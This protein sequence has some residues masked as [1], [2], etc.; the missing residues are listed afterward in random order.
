MIE[1]FVPLDLDS[2]VLTPEHR[3]IAASARETMQKLAA[4]GFAWTSYVHGQV[5]AVMCAA[6]MPDGCEVFIFP[7]ATL[8]KRNPF[9]LFKDVATKL[10]DAKA[11]F[12]A[13]RSVT[14]P[15]AP[16]ANRF[17]AHL[18]FKRE[19]MRGEFLVWVLAP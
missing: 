18:G 19:G 13:V 1:I 17:L 15:D 14:R 16:A 10:A 7:S 11:R 8:A 4:D 9:T 3:E 6:P 12:G 2:V 5:L